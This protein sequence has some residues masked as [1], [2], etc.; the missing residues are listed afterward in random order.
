VSCK[1]DG[2]VTNQTT[3]YLTSEQWLKVFAVS[4]PVEQEEK[5]FVR[6]LLRR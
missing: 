4:G 3:C 2:T 6:A 1:S 5:R